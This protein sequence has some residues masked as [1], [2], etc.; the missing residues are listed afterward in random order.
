[1]Y[2]RDKIYVRALRS[3]FF[4]VGRE[5]YT[6]YK[7]LYFDSLMQGKGRHEEFLEIRFTYTGLR[8]STSVRGHQGLKYK[9]ITQNFRFIISRQKKHFKNEQRS[10]D[11]AAKK[12]SEYKWSRE[13]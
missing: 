6:V 5:R 3:Q 11:A 13:N 9:I 2:R 1:M 4:F 7:P 12:M 8:V 10:R